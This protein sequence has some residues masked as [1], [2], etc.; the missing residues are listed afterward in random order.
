MSTEHFISPLDHAKEQQ[1]KPYKHTFHHTDNM[2]VGLNTLSQGQSQPLHDHAGQDKFYLVLAGS[3][4][5]TVGDSSQVC[6]RGELILAPAGVP[7]GVVNEE[8]EPLTFLTVIAP[9]PVSM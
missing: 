8:R 1:D 3:G 4:H 9:F 5:F 7:H 6:G 2:L